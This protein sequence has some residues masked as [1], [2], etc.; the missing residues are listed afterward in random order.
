MIRSL[1]P[2]RLASLLALGLLLAFETPA[3][4]QQDDVLEWIGVITLRPAF[5]GAKSAT[6]RWTRKPTISL[7]DASTEET[8]ILE[9]VVDDVNVPIA[10]T[11][12]KKLT[13]GRPNN[14]K[15]DIQVHFVLHEK[16]PALAKRLQC[17]NFEEQWPSFSLSFTNAKSE[18]DHAHIVLA[19]DKLKGETL[20]FHAIIGMT[21]AIGLQNDSK[22]VKESVFAGNGAKLTEM[23]RKLVVF[24]YNALPPGSDMPELLAAY[25]KS[26]PK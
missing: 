18:L 4:A 24:F 5:G 8:K 20:R 3:F 25:K 10:K 16:M 1:Q 19:T 21:G 17:T 14:K 7:L 6:R 22:L 26:W 13:L 23:D 2:R 12:L 15:A 9:E 11:F